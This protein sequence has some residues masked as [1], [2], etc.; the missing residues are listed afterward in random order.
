MTQLTMLS[1]FKISY[2]TA[3]NIQKRDYNVDKAFRS[4]KILNQ[5]PEMFLLSFR[6]NDLR[7]GRLFLVAN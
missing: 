7:K 2:K 4:F 6:S 5:G 3:K 1:F